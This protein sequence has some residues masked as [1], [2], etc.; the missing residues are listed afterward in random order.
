M[1]T[2]NEPQLRNGLLK[3]SWNLPG[4]T[5]PEVWELQQEAATLWV[6]TYHRGWRR[7][8]L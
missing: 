4:S 7:S 8:N 6:Y 5:S 1:C 2:I 3:A